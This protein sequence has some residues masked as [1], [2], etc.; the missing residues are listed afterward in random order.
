[1]TEIEKYQQ[2]IKDLEL[3]VFL[4]TDLNL[5]IGD[6]IF[7]ANRLGIERLEITEFYVISYDSNTKVDI[8][9]VNENNNMIKIKAPYDNMK[10]YESIYDWYDI[11]LTKKEALAK[12]RKY[13]STEIEIALSHIKDG[14]SSIFKATRRYLYA[15]FLG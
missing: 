1:M 13:I 2:Q 5:K 11:Q 12:H 14:I 8:I 6:K 10:N 9:C 15:K 7:T 4:L 3:E